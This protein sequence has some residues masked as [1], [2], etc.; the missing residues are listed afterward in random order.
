MRPVEERNCSSWQRRVKA[1]FL[2]ACLSNSDRVFAILLAGLFPAFVSFA[3]S[4]ALGQ[5]KKE[6]VGELH[7][8]VT[9]H[10][11]HSLTSEEAKRGHPIH[12]RGVATYFDPDIGHG[13]A[14][15]FVHDSTGSIFVKTSGGSIKPPLAGT[16]VEVQGV[17]NIGGF[18]PIVDRPQIQV[19]RYSKVPEKAI[20]VSRIQLFAGEFDGQW[21]EVEGIVH[22][23]SKNGHELTLNLAMTDVTIAA[24]TVEE[25]GV[26]YRSLID[27]RVRIHGNE[28]PLFNSTNQ[29]VGA[30]IMFPNHSAVK[31]VESAPNDP[32]LRPIIPIDN[33]FRWSQTSGMQHR[34]HLRGRVTMQ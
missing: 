7:T 1:D 22:A 34:V 23:V 6:P 16:L 15:L 2:A 27:A 14:T 24:T 5:S 11:A 18:A 17:S 28:A 29:M 26:A 19:I 20:P 10:E 4:E 31:V 3:G 12:V 21:V 25:T 13:L 8:L 9:A 30:H 33:L 32:F